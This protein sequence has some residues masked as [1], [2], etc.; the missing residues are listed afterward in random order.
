VDAVRFTRAHAFG[1]RGCTRYV[2]RPCTALHRLAGGRD[3]ESVSHG[4]GQG[5]T[6][7]HRGIP[8]AANTGRSTW[9]RDVPRRQVA[10]GGLAP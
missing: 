10:L 5:R 8:T 6:K 3:V 2:G 7:R 1:H 9:L 4:L